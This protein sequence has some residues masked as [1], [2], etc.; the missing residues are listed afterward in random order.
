MKRLVFSILAA[1]FLHSAAAAQSFLDLSKTANVGLDEPFDEAVAGVQD[2]KKK[3]GFRELPVGRQV[4]R[5]VPFQILDPAKNQDRS[6]VVLKGRHKPD[7]PEGVSIPAGHL[8][9]SNLY[10]LHTCRWGGTAPNITVAEYDVVYEDGQVTAIPLRVG[11]EFTNFFGADDTSASYLGWWYKYKN[12]GMGVN[13]F[14]WKNPRP[15]KAIESILF[16]S[17]G[18]MPVPI[19]LAIT[20]SDKEI[21]ISPDS[22]KPEKTFQTD[23]SKWISLES[24][25][26]SPA[27]TAI[28]MSFLLD[29]PAG[30]HG[31]VKVDGD[32]L[33]FEDG[34]PAKFW[35]ARVATLPEDEPAMDKLV[36]RLAAAGCNLVS[37]PMFVTPHGPTG[38]I[39]RAIEFSSKL[40]AKGIYTVFETPKFDS[41]GNEDLKFLSVGPIPGELMLIHPLNQ[42]SQKNDP[43]HITSIFEKDGSAPD[44]SAIQIVGSGWDLRDRVMTPLVMDLEKNP[45][46]LL[47][48]KRTF[49]RPFFAFWDIF[50]PNEYLAE[51]PVLFSAYASFEGWAGAVG[52]Y[53]LDEQFGPSFV[54]GSNDLIDSP[55]LLAQWPVASLAYLRGDLKEGKIF[56][57][58]KD[59]LPLKALAHKS[60]INPEGGNFKTD[61]SGELKAKINEKTKSF[62]SDTGQITWQ[63]NVGIVKIEAPRFQALIGFLAN[64]KFNN[65]Y[66]GVQTSNKFASISA[67]SL[68]KKPLNT[69]DHLLLTGVTRMEN[70]G[71]VYNAAKTKLISAGTAPILAEPLS[72]KIVLYRFAKDPKLKVRALDANGQPIKAKVPTKWVKNN[73]V[74]SWIPSAFHLELYK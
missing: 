48:A 53:Y 38:E 14:P 16:K 69:S 42:A 62:V 26:A 4:F 49:N 47:S 73:L 21:P 51:N 56:V 24:S 61:V 17:R 10:F 3:D 40:N 52:C 22:P 1:G 23:T 25:I 57:L 66:W 20:A 43:T 35:G 41:T 58:N 44:S 60:G 46:E 18:S 19:L 71:Q 54:G 67:I 9:A 7:F 68:V 74:L 27:G 12:A 33:V 37:S 28:D 2:L 34:T 64:R 11:V 59:G 13:V 72:A 32:K 63:G 50:W 6:L 36:A 15:D 45:L 65:P 5:G 31:K 39:N 29:A 55:S 8:K 70:T 30:K